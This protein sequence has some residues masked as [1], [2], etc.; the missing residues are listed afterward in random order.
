MLT[1]KRGEDDR[2]SPQRTPSEATLRSTQFFTENHPT[3]HIR[4]RVFAGLL[5]LLGIVAAPATY[6]QKI[7]YTN[8]EAILANMP[9]M[10]DVQQTLKQEA[11][12]Q[13]RELQQQQ[14]KFQKQ[15]QQYQQQQSLLSD[16]ARSQRERELR[17]MRNK[18]QQASQERQQELRQREREL[19]QPLLEDL[20]GAIDSVAAARDIDVV[21][22]TQAL[23]YVDQNSGSVV[24][25]TQ[26]VAQQ[27]GINL[28]QQP[29]EPSPSVDP[30]A[31]A[32]PTGGGDQ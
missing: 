23:L 25:I 19:M 1:E 3:M 17:R 31:N 10:Q 4:V 12:Q 32:P 9:E 30:G 16:S 6:G 20:Q 29:S 11:R 7:G 26:E 8:Q 27:L 28:D 5:I 21:M 13:Q 24:D 22:R 15:V 14:K 2:G 18:L